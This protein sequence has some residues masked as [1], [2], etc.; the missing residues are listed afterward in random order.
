MSPGGKKIELFGRPDNCMADWLTLGNQLTDIR[1]SDQDIINRY[2][3][4]YP[5]QDLN[6]S[7]M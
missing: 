4:A 7:R 5:N 6:E 1:L 2:R 3:Q